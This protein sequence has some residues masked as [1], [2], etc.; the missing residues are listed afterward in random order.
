MAMLSIVIDGIV[1]QPVNIPGLGIVPQVHMWW[2]KHSKLLPSKQY[3]V[4]CCTFAS[5]YGDVLIQCNAFLKLRL[6]CV[7]ERKQS[8]DI[9]HLNIKNE[10]LTKTNSKK[11]N[12]LLRKFENN[13]SSQ[14]SSK[15]TF[16]SVFLT[17]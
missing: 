15:Q 1:K 13:S 14:K 2:S 4:G 12:Y 3:T 10:I 8:W 9:G 17:V 7:L 5:G 6:G 16:V 11:K